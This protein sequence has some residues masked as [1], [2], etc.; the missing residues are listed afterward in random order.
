[1]A[2]KRSGYWY[3]HEILSPDLLVGGAEMSELFLTWAN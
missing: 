3:R 2:G 1:M